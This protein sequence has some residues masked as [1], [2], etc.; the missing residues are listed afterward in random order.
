[1][2]MAGVQVNV[3]TTTVGFH[4]FDMILLVEFAVLVMAVIVVW[5]AWRRTSARGAHHRDA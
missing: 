2:T 3:T 4:W 5:W 1:M